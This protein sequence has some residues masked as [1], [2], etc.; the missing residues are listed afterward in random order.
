LS[1]YRKLNGERAVDEESFV[2]VLIEA[3]HL[4]NTSMEEAEAKD[5]MRDFLRSI[6]GIEGGGLVLKQVPGWRVRDMRH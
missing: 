3:A 1:S 5:L 4:T 6:E 2:S